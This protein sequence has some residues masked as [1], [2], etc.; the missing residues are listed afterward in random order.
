MT[1]LPFCPL[2]QSLTIVMMIVIII[3]IIITIISHYKKI[4]M[5]IKCKPFD[6]IFLVGY[7][8]T[9]SLSLIFSQSSVSYTSDSHIGL[10]H[11]IKS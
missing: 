8:F 4:I 6:L 9:A 11:R 5:N 2:L 10:L 1:P 3:V 7:I